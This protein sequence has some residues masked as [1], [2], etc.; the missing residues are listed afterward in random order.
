MKEAN[1]QSTRFPTF[2]KRDTAV[3]AVDLESRNKYCWDWLL[4]KDTSGD[5][6]CI[7]S[8]I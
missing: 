4:L 1:E 6:F 7:I 8:I 5:F 3:D 2:V